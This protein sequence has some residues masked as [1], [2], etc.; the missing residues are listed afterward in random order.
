[1]TASDSKPTVSDS[2]L[3]LHLIATGVVKLYEAVKN[4]KAPSLPYPVELQRGLD[5]LVLV[6]LGRKEKPPQGVPDL[7]SWCRRP[8]AEWPLELPEDA[9]TGD[10]LLDGQ[11]PTGICDEWAIASSDVEAELTQNKLLINVM[12]V[13]RPAKAPDSY[14]AFR[15]LLISEPV[16]TAFDLLKRCNDPLL[17]RLDKQIHDAYELAPQSCA[18]EGQFHCCSPCGNIMLRTVKGELICAEERCRVKG[19]AKA[20][21]QIAQKEEVFWLKRGLRR[22]IA[23]PGLAELRLEEKLKKLGLE[24]ELWPNFDSYDLRIVFADGEAWAIDVKDWANPFLLAR[25]LSQ[26]VSQQEPLIP[27]NP[28]WSKAYFVFPDD[29]RQQRT[30]YLRAFKHNCNLPKVI[31]AK[32]EKDFIKDVKRKL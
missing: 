17:E 15:R 29:R 12:E 24:V 2:E 22:F 7:L 26:K 23:A 28:P 14:V 30:D 4:G 11:S 18:L 31:K 10:K 16:L 13:C 32:F 5:R 20:G 19:V 21:R 9:G 8:L 6:C 25:K 1:M 3:T 27:S